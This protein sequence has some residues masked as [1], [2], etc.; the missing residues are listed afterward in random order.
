MRKQNLIPKGTVFG[1]LTVIGKS[2]R[3]SGAW[4]C[5]CQ[6][7]N[8]REVNRTHLMQGSYKSCGCLRKEQFTKMSR[9]RSSTTC[10]TSR[11]HPAYF[12][13]VSMHTRCTNPNCKDWARYGG[14]GIAVCD[15]WKVFEN[16]L[17]D[18]GARPRGTSIDRIDNDGSYEPGNC[19]WADAK[20]QRNNACNV[21]IVEYKGESMSL[22]MLAETVG[23]KRNTLGKRLKRGMSVD[24]AVKTPL[25]RT[26]L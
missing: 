22:S 19:R 15:R 17:M 4:I 12:S 14:R 21:H 25:R 7:G 10:D 24:Q 3:K 23:I 1:R 26:S 16:F 11:D 5:R 9:D 2:T 13:W 18:M 20:T 8:E 6:C